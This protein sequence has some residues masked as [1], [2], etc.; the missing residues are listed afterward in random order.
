[1]SDIIVEVVG[2][3]GNQL[4]QYAFYKNLKLKEKMHNV[5]LYTGRFNEIRDN[6]GFQ[7][8][9]YF[10]NADIERYENEINHLIDGNNFGSKLKVKIFGGKS[11]FY[12]EDNTTFNDIKIIDNKDLY[13]RGLWQ[14][15]KYFIDSVEDVRKDLSFSREIVVNN[16][17]QWDIN[18]KYVSL[19]VRRGDY[20][21]NPKYKEL[22]GE[23]CDVSY[24]EKAISCMQSLSGSPLCFMIFSDDQTWVKENL[25]IL[26]SVN[27]VYYEGE[28]DIDDLYMMSKC[29]YHI[30]ANSTFS[31]WGAYLNASPQ[32]IVIGPQK[33]YNVKSNILPILPDT[34]IAI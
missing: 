26:K 5:Y 4:F 33:W 22:L 14:S 7:I 25:S 23:V 21:S 20:I 27:T 18:T 19:H 15:E 31:W 32:K 3:L 1:M 12:K 30:I 6:K 9:N 28:R 24:Y 34:W 10:K 2:G 11:T 16:V 13:I 29:D 8:E 17:F